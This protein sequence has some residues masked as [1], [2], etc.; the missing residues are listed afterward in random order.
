MNEAG[1]I[2]WLWRSIDGHDV[3]ETGHSGHLG[4]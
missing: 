1:L 2:D 4:E 3:I